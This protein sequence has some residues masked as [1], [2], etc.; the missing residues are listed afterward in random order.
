MNTAGPHEPLA[1]HVADATPV[2]GRQ[3]W[4]ENLLNRS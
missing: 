1:P 3:A 2:S 4:L